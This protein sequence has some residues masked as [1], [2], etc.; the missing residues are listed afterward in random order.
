MGKAQ[1]YS[2]AAGIHPDAVV[3]VALDVGCDNSALR[4]S[5]EYTGMQ[6]DRLQGSRYEAFV[7]EFHS[8]CQVRRTDTCVHQ[9]AP[10]DDS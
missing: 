10:C 3:P 6:L 5:P 2:V 4:D 7:D 9:A 8:A 1:L